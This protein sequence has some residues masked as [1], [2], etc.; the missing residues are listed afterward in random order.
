MNYK[1]IDIRTLYSDDPSLGGISILEG[2]D[3]IPFDIK[4]IFYVHG[5]KEHSIRGCHAHKAHRQFL[6]CPYGSVR[7]H[8]DD[9]VEKAEVLLSS[10]AHGLL[11]DPC[12]W[13]II[14]YVED[15]S[16]LCVAASEH[17]SEDDYIRDY[18]QFQAYVKAEWERENG[19]EVHSTEPEL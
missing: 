7:I 16:I 9:G 17:Y 19:S 4:R 5:T 10:A 3:D 13:S 15:N 8:L 11:I 1:L 18:D 12:V 2:G 6:F 14:E